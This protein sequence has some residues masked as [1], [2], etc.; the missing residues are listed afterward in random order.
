[1]GLAP[2]V[3]H[4]RSAGLV[5]AF[6]ALV[7]PE[8]VRG[9]SEGVDTERLKAHERAGATRDDYL[10]L[11]VNSSYTYSVFGMA[12][13][14]FAIGGMLVWVPNFLFSTRGIEQRGPTRSWAWSPCA[15]R[16]PA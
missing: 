12:A 2:G 4:R 8:P 7:L 5:A 13:Y 6:A 11:M 15:P 14:T 9:A 16:S 1:M 10:D 3:L